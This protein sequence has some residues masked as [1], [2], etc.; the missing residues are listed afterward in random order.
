MNPSLERIVNWLRVSYPT[1][2]PERDYQPL[3]A[4]MRRRLSPEEM[5]EL[6]NHLVADGLVPADRVDVGV[7]ITKVTQVLPS[8]QEMDR[9]LDHLHEC[10]FPL[11]DEFD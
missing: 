6:G 10:G 8:P 2:V 5:H 1:G 11:H 7:G 9:V 3:L 4:L